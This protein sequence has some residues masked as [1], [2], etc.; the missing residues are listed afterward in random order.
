MNWLPLNDPAQLAEI[1]QLSISRPVLI[2]KHSTRCNISAAALA[3][4]DRSGTPERL[5]PAYYLDLLRFRPLSNAIEARYG[6]AHASPQVLIIRNGKCV[7]DTSHFGIVFRDV[8]AA[9]ERAQ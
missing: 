9:M 1:D 7:F 6:I 2:L 8:A 5:E 4:L 3:R